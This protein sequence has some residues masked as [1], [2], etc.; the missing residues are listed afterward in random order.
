MIKNHFAQNKR[1][2][3]IVDDDASI[4][5]AAAKLLQLQGYTTTEADSA[6][7]CLNICQN[8]SPDLILL[9][10]ISGMDGFNCL[11]KIKSILGIQCL[12][13]FMMTTLDECDSIY[14]S[15]DARITDYFENIHNIK[16]IKENIYAIANMR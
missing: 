14:R 4:R 5:K 3:L 6:E 11:L 12:P 1:L 10:A 13:I 15:F 9:G 16:Q 2:I 8:Q 7:A